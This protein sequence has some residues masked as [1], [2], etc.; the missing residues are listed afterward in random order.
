MVSRHV[1]SAEGSELPVTSAAPAN[2]NVTV[3]V[4]D[5]K[6]KEHLPQLPP[7]RKSSNGVKVHIQNGTCSLIRRDVSGDQMKQVTFT[8]YH[9]WTPIG[10]H[11]AG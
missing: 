8:E 9:Y 2:Q 7:R 5:G 6:P 3:N 10:G 4:P 1:V 11:C